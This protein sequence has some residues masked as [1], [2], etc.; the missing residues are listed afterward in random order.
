VGRADGIAE[1]G[2]LL[3]READGAARRIRAGTVELAEPS[4]TP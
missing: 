2:A 1:D 4:F 3:V